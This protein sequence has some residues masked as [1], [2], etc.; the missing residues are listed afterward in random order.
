MNDKELFKEI[1]EITRTNYTEDMNRDDLIM[2]LTDMVYEY[3]KKEEELEA[4]IDDR[5]D[6]WERR[7]NYSLYGV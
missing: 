6:N 2:A 5:N 3:K 4:V 1:S 7:S